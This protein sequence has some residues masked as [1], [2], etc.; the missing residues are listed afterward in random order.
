MD[1]LIQKRAENELL[2]EIERSKMIENEQ[3]RN[4]RRNGA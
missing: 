3:N 4:Y 2:K 1:I